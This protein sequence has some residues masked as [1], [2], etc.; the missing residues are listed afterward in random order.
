MA[1]AG[2]VAFGVFFEKCI[3]FIIVHVVSCCFSFVVVKYSL[4]LTLGLNTHVSL[5]L[6]QKDAKLNFKHENKL[7]VAG[8][9]DHSQNID[10]SALGRRGPGSARTP[11]KI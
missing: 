5:E 10:N 1:N 3:Y 9:G 8:R 4:C 6:G 7:G 11:R 2:I